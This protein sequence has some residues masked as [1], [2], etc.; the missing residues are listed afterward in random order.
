MLKGEMNPI[1]GL[2]NNRVSFDILR[3]SVQYSIFT[4]E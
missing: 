3:F 2:P 4:K 1:H